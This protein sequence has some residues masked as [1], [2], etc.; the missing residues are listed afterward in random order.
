MSF[1][2]VLVAAISIECDEA[3]VMAAEK[4][5][6]KFDAHATALILAV[7]PASRFA[8][9]VAPLSEILLDLAA[10]ARN[11][12][13]M[14]RNK[15]V[16]RL[17]RTSVDFE[18]RDLVIEDAIVDRQVLAHARH[19]DLTIV[20]RSLDP[21]RDVAHRVLLES[22]L[23]GSGRPLLLLPCAWRREALWD[24][25]VIGWSA[26]RE[27]SRAV[28]DAMPFLRLAREVIVATVDAKP[29]ADGHGQ[30][31]GHDLA[32]HLARHGVRVEVKNIDGMGRSE[33]AALLDECAAIDADMMVIGGFGHSR[34]SEWVFG[35]VTKEL[36][37]A[38]SIPLLLSH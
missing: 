33:G 8:P 9:E 4:I 36:L 28:A 3:A 12:A 38:A 16:E 17:K 18:V 24:R 20:A 23:F 32:A 13:A 14:E 37:N 29:R 26:T 21:T 7:F 10:G 15:I 30:A 5:A 31:P 11:H 35:G 6:V 1:K 27:A 2:D 25:I 22:V 19:A 34:V